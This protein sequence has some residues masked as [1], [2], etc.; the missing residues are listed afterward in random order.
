M[1]EFYTEYHNSKTEPQLLCPTALSA[2]LYLTSAS[3]SQII[4][5]L[6]FPFASDQ[7]R[8]FHFDCSKELHY[9][10]CWPLL[11]TLI[12]SSVFKVRMFQSSKDPFLSAEKDACYKVHCRPITV[13]AS[14]RDRVSIP[15]TDPFK[16][17]K[18]PEMDRTALSAAAKFEL[19]LTLE[20]EVKERD[21][22]IRSLVKQLRRANEE[23]YKLLM[24]LSGFRG[25]AREKLYKENK[26]LK[27][28]L[29]RV[30]RE[31]L[32]IRGLARGEGRE[33]EGTKGK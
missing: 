1:V 18:P 12:L 3:P 21:G 25:P 24:K 33:R 9:P 27:E 5:T 20:Q 14:Q 13:G 10:E 23:N 19:A 30:T 16:W 8:V 4:R 29:A 31:N 28:R 17:V 7:T 6:R 15:N 11:D 32:L 26:V 22:V 2:V